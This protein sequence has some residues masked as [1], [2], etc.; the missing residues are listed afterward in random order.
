[1]QWLPWEDAAFAAGGTAAATRVLASCPAT[2]VGA[3]RSW[4]RELSVMFGL[5]ALWQF[6]GNLSIAQAS[7]AIARG[8]DIARAEAW[9]HLPSEASFQRVF[10]GDRGLLRAM[11]F[12]YVGLHVALTGVC[13]VWLF[14]FHRDRYPFV[15]NTMALATGACLLVAL[16]PVAPPRLIPGLGLVDTGRLVGPT[17]YPTT[18]RP[19][20]DQL[21]AMPSVHVAWATIVAGAV[22]YTLRSRWKWLALCYPALTTLVVVVTGNHYWADGAAAVVI[23]AFAA[24]GASV[25]PAVTASISRRGDEALAPVP[26]AAT[27]VDASGVQVLDGSLLRDRAAVLHRDDVWSE[28]RLQVAGTPPAPAPPPPLCADAGNGA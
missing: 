20:L 9:L 2:W 28:A 5:Y 3:I 12:Y 27:V 19:G 13:L 26:L 8:T 22:V 11:N 10:I 18:A 14:A 4:T 21:S 16:L 25:L 17:V 15:R 1:M 6:A 23:C 7:G 24:A